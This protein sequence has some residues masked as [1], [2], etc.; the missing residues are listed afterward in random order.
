MAFIGLKCYVVLAGNQIG[1]SMPV[2]PL[3]IFIHLLYDGSASFS[4]FI[5]DRLVFAD[6]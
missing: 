5:S 3:M 2:G 1:V 4:A 6:Y